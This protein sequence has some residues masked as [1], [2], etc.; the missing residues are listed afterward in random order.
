MKATTLSELPLTR[1][2]QMLRAAERLA[3]PLSQSACLIRRALLA[4]RHEIAARRKE[5]ANA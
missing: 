4:R 2:L 5:A 3:G 1:L